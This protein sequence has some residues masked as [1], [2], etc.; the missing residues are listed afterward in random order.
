MISVDTEALGGACCNQDYGTTL[1]A[2]HGKRGWRAGKNC[3]DYTAHTWRPPD[4]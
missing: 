4:E 3:H 2:L 1:G